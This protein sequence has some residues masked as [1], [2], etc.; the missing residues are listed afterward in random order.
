MSRF[1]G[2]TAV[3]TGGNSGI[4]L[5]TAQELASNGAKVVIAGRDQTTLDA[6]V[7]SLG[8]NAFGVKADVSNLS[9]ITALFEQPNA[10]FGKIDI[11][12]VNA[13][14]AKFAPIEQSDEAMFD[15]IVNI[16]FKGSYFTVKNALPFLNDGASIIFTTTVAAKIGMAGASV[17]AA[18]KAAIHALT[19]IFAAE[20]V[21]RNIRVNAVSPGPIDTPI[22]DRMGAPD[23]AKKEM[24]DGIADKVPM[25]RFG[26][27]GEVA[28][29]VAFLASDDSSFITGVE[30]DVDG[31]MGQL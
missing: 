18:S 3:V 27:V 4:G 17:Y 12:F 31:G 15:E 21:G 25:K 19:K 11:L 22:F 5:A 8:E 20:L 30:I 9:D 16:N 26:T 7:A 6:A 14:I 10:K 29:T 2:K 13:G 24:K 28:K 23:E 1:T